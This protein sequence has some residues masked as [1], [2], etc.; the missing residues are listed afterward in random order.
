MSWDLVNP[1]T[2]PNMIYYNIYSS[3]LSQPV[4]TTTVTGGTI[5]PVTTINGNSGQAATGPSITLTGGSTGLIFTGAGNTISLSGVLV[6]ANGGTGQ[7]SYT[8][9]DLLAASAATTLTKLTAGTNNARLAA[10]STQTTGLI[11]IN[12]STGWSNWTGTDSR[13]AH[14]TY[15]G[16]ASVG[17]VQAELQGVMDALKNVTEAMKSLIADLTTQKLLNS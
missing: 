17:Y 3:T 8:K 9:G 16:T 5:A 11:W 12:A 2:D 10:D 13:A 4:I 7:L 1:D 15:S 14:A 6:A